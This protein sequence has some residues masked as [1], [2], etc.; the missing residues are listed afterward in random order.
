MKKLLA[1]VIACSLF[2]AHLWLYPQ[3]YTA[4][5]LLDQQARVR[6]VLPASFTN[7]ASLDFKGLAADFQFLQA[8]FF[9]G[10]KIERG[11]TITLKDWAYFKRIILA[12]TDLDPYFFDPYYLAGGMLA[13][14]PHLY[15]DAIDILKKGMKYRPN[16]RRLPLTIGFYYFYFLNDSQKGAEYIAKAAQMPGAPSYYATL[17]ARLS[18]YAGEHEASVILLKEMLANTRDERIRHKYTKRL[19]AIEG[20]IFLERAVSRYQKV[21][22]ENPTKLKELV[23]AGIVDELPEEPYGGEWFIMEGN[24]IFSTSKFVDVR[25]NSSRSKH[26]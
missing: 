18:Y 16:E 7:I 11:E 1:L 14:G 17:A 21:H 25:E 24:R 10:E 4:K 26:H 15:E 19:K 13:W 8:N 3:V 9:I 22:E 5:S 6:Y 12:V 2:V 20:A 23:S